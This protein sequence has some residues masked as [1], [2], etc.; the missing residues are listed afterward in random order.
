MS[1]SPF[2]KFIGQKKN[3]VVKEEFRQEK[4]QAKKERAAFFE[5]LKA[6]QYAARQAKKQAPVAPAKSKTANDSRPANKAQKATS[7]SEGPK[8]NGITE[9]MPLNKY[10]AHCGVCS[11]R[12]AVTIIEEGK[13][14]VNNKVLTEPGY[15]VLPAYEI[16][17]N[18]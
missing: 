15:K 11:R 5:K 7:K 16:F 2:Q 6:E 17:F 12:E 4:K 10:L 3:S 8:T 14:K 9:Q 18:G 13:V 1:N